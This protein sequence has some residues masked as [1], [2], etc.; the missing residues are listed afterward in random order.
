MLDERQFEYGIT[1]ISEDSR[2]QR[3]NPVTKH[4]TKAYLIHN[5][6]LTLTLFLPRIILATV[7]VSPS[8]SAL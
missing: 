5:S 8:S 6:Y 2:C 1:Y 4:L 3:Y 7:L